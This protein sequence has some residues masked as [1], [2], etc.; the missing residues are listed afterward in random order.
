MPGW[1]HTAAS[2]FTHTYAHQQTALMTPFSPSDS[3]AGPTSWF[4]SGLLLNEGAMQTVIKSR[5]PSQ[6]QRARLEAIYFT[7]EWNPEILLSFLCFRLKAA[8]AP[9]ITQKDLSA[10]NVV[11]CEWNEKPKVLFKI[12]RSLWISPTWGPS[13]KWA[14]RLICLRPHTDTNTPPPFRFVLFEFRST[15]LNNLASWLSF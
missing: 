15:L 10:M 7:S 1:P 13:R 2:S 6:Q 9:L 4:S 14:F 11:V 8:A 5:L 3:S 12:Q